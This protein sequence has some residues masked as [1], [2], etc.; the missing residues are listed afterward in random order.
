M[1]LDV[2]RPGLRLGTSEL[3][4]RCWTGWDEIAVLANSRRVLAWTTCRRM[5]G[6]TACWSAWHLKQT[7]YS[8]WAVAT[9]DPAALTPSTWPMRGGMVGAAAVPDFIVCGPWQ[10]EQSELFGTWSRW[11]TGLPVS[12]GLSLARS[13]ATFTA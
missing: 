13:A 12:W 7:S 9:G 3:R 11:S 10:S 1:T 8:Y 5:K 6:W 2:V 4:P